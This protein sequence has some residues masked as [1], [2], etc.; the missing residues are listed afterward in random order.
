MQTI[1]IIIRNLS[2]LSILVSLIV[3]L[4]NFKILTDLKPLF[5][6]CILSI[7]QDVFTKILTISFNLNENEHI[8]LSYLTV[9][10]YVLLEFT[11]LSFFIYK[12]TSN[13]KLFYFSILFLFCL[14]IF[15]SLINPSSH[16]IN[17]KYFLMFEGFFILFFVIQFLLKEIRKKILFNIFSDPL[18][19]VSMGIFLSFSLIWPGS[20]LI[21]LF[22]H[23]LNFY[24]FYYLFFEIINF[25][26]YIILFNSF[27]VAFYARQK[28][29]HL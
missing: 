8:F 2:T 22:N 24:N 21:D 12:I 18:Y 9:D 14:I 10:I 15:N 26:G 27:T 16:Y 11:F 4:K 19:I 28:S 13:K 23:T 20:L 1:E 6:I 29:N 25:S 17:L 5:I 3:G 7:S